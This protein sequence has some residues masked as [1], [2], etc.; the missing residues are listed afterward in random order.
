MNFVTYPL[1]QGLLYGG[2]VLVMISIGK[3]LHELCPA[4]SR[5]REPQHWVAVQ[6]RRHA[7]RP[8][9]AAGHR[10]DIR[11]PVRHRLRSVARPRPPPIMDR[12]L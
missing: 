8:W 3:A 4:G 1:V 7:S 10:G 2:V 9:E 12:R 6:Q 5:R 11:Y